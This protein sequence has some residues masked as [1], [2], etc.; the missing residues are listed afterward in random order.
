MMKMVLYV[1]ASFVLSLCFHSSVCISAIGKSGM[2]RRGTSFTKNHCTFLTSRRI[3][4]GWGIP[5]IPPVPPNEKGGSF[6]NDD[7]AAST[8]MMGLLLFP[9]KNTSFQFMHLPV[10]YVNDLKLNILSLVSVF[11][12][13]AESKTTNNNNYEVKQILWYNPFSRKE[14]DTKSDSSSNIMS[15]NW[16]KKLAEQLSL[17]GRRGL[18]PLLIPSIIN[19]LAV[20]REAAPFC[21]HRLVQYLP[22]VTVAASILLLRE[23]GLQNARILLRGALFASLMSML[24][25]TYSAGGQWVTMQPLRGEQRYAGYAVVTGASSGLGK[26][27]AAL[28]FAHGYNL[29]LVGR[30]AR[31]LRS[32]RSAI[33]RAQQMGIPVRDDEDDDVDGV[34]S[35]EGLEETEEETVEAAVDPSTTQD[36]SNATPSSTTE[37]PLQ[38]PSDIK[39]FPNERTGDIQWIA[40][41]LADG[42]APTRIRNLLRIR[43]LLD[44]VDVLVNNAGMCARGP[45]AEMSGSASSECV[46]VNVQ[47]AVGLTQLLLPDMLLRRHRLAP[48]PPPS[49][50]LFVGSVA[51]S[52]PGPGAA[53]YSASKAFLS[54][55]S[56]SLRRELLPSGVLV[57]LGQPGATTGTRLFRSAPSPSSEEDPC[58]LSLPFCSMSVERTAAAMF[59]AV[60]SGRA[61]VT[62]GLLNNVYCHLLSRIL[63]DAL[64]GC[65]TQAAWRPC[66]SWLRSF[67]RPCVTPQ[68][69]IEG[70]RNTFAACAAHSY[71]F[72]RRPLP[73]PK[74]PE[75]QEGVWEEGKVD[76]DGQEMVKDGQEVD[77]AV[78][79]DV[80][81]EVRSVVGIHRP[82]YRPESR[83]AWAV[84]PEL[85]HFFPGGSSGV[86]GCKV[87]INGLLEGLQQGMDGVVN[88]AVQLGQLYPN[89]TLSRVSEDASGLLLVQWLLMWV[90]RSEA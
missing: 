13:Q 64:L 14:N 46:Q 77:S 33:L 4:G 24:V 12:Q 56:R 83:P 19:Q 80:F 1:T 73:A 17:S 63:P 79:R 6:P 90:P 3:S 37:D 34:E 11:E 26:H 44:Q 47:A 31:R 57:T 84:T 35:E 86:R 53:V 82:E 85:T 36:N 20:L 71:H 7:A 74:S 42:Y 61:T 49:R 39:E 28:L 30:S 62:P 48:H 55:F 88:C 22:Q 25:D 41:D 59:A 75:E 52:G 51:G 29:V 76:K 69:F 40:C 45:F 60:R 87:D 66:P 21:I 5:P 8:S 58:I 65:I 81:G 38:I 54:T 72:Y 70:L 67:S 16:R 43:G 27:L 23:R 89:P 10:K 15:S 18:L 50:I 9:P 68:G 78:D 2:H 32:A